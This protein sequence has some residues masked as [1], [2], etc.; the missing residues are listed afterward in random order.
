MGVEKVLPFW[1]VEIAWYSTDAG[2]APTAIPIGIE[3]RNK[4]MPMR[5]ILRSEELTVRAGPRWFID[6]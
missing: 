5:I 1:M 3:A 2:F 4:M 6:F